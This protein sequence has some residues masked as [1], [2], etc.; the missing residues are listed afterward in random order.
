MHV[1]MLDINRQYWKTFPIRLEDLKNF[2]LINGIAICMENSWS[3]EI[4]GA[5]FH[6]FFAK[7]TSWYP[8]RI[9]RCEAWRH[10]IDLPE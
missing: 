2:I 5:F 4:L 7:N 8:L 9:E 10:A 6:E 3:S 1:P